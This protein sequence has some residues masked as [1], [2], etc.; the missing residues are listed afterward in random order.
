MRA[1]L[2][3]LLLASAAVPLA[4]ADTFQF[5]FNGNYAPLPPED[6]KT[7]PLGAGPT[8]SFSWQLSAP[9]TLEPPT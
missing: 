8:L 5:T 6:P 1:Y 2:L 3:P 7:D 4:H 9:P